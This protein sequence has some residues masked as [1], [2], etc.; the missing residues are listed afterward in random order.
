MINEMLNKGV[1]NG[2]SP[3]KVSEKIFEGIKAKNLI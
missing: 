2:M 3:Q 1:L